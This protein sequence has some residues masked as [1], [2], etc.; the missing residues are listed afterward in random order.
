MKWP[1]PEGHLVAIKYSQESDSENKMKIWILLSDKL[2][3]N[4]AEINEL[5][6]PGIYGPYKISRFHQEEFYWLHEA[7]VLNYLF[8]ELFV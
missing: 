7:L 2:G 1:V 6:I 5:P 3:I 8:G 4:K